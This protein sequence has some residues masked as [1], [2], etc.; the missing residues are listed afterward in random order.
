MISV[1]EQHILREFIDFVNLQVGVYMDAVAGFQGH[2]ARTSRLVHRVSRAQRVTED[3]AG[4]TTVVYAS[5]EDPSQ[6]DVIHN[7]ITR[8]AD[9]I[10]ANSEGGT[11]YQQHSWAILIFLFTFWEDG[12]RPRL[13][14][15]A[16]VPARDIR[17]DIMGDLRILRNSILHSKG[18][19]T[20]GEHGKLRM[21]QST[22]RPDAT[23]VVTYEDMHRIFVLVKQDIASRLLPPDAPI[24]AADIRD[25]GIQTR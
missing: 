14:S 17:S 12:F 9:Y 2:S 6:P 10:A 13:A 16:G 3:E 19:L 18:I 20:A 21:V 7:R 11:N 1:E 25:I 8:A 5:F 22:F 15:A 24:S 4:H 23:I